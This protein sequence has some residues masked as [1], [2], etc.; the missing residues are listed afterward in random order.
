MIS[1]IDPCPACGAL[2]C[3]WVNNPHL[4]PLSPADNG[5]R[6]EAVL[7]I[8]MRGFRERLSAIDTTDLI[9]ASLSPTTPLIADHANKPTTDAVR[10]EVEVSRFR[11]KGTITASQW[12]KLGDHPDVIRRSCWPEPRD[13]CWRYWVGRLDAGFVVEPGDWI[14]TD[15][16]GITRPIKPEI[17]AKTYEPAA[18]HPSP[19][20]PIGGQ[21]VER[22]ARIISPS[23]WD[24]M[25]AEK[26]RMLRKYKGQNIGYDPEQFQHRE[27]MAT[28]RKI[29]AAL[30]APV[31]RKGEG[32]AIYEECAAICEQQ[33]QD[34]LSPQYATGQPIS[35]I[36]ERFACAECATAIRAAGDK[37]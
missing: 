17:F 19:E 21:D 13:E 27:S 6:R 20:D 15:S 12:F 28:A 7:P 25:D 3:D 30:R 32:K 35:S 18:L 4:T 24:V 16:G 14:C 33:A 11:K 29:L 2:P 31:E 23:A 8:V 26:A 10:G 5:A 9:I 22:V 34:F 37:A 36:Q 1:D